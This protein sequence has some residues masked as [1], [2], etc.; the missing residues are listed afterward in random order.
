MEKVI[1]YCQ[2][3]TEKEIKD[4][5]ANG[6]KTLKEIQEA[7]GAGTGNQCSERNPT[8]KCCSGDIQAILKTGSGS[9]TCCCCS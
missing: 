6:A 8:G 9:A 3:V 5:M 4:A 1:C 2:Q 7:T